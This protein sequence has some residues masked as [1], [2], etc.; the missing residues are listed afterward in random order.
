MDRSRR[1]SFALI[2]GCAFG[3]AACSSGQHG[4]AAPSSSGTRASVAVPATG[5]HY[6]ASISLQGQPEVT[7]D[8]KNIVVTV[9]VKNTGAGTFGSQTAPHNV[10][11][12][13]HS[14][15]AS[16]AVV[17]NDLARG[18]LPQVKPGATVTATI[19]MPTDQLIGNRAEILPVQEGVAWFDKWGTTPLIVGPF[20]TCSGTAGTTVCGPSGKYALINKHDIEDATSY[21]LRS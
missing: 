11:L 5:Q 15:D 1:L 17:N 7:A 9:Q 8:G 18:H 2:L 21:A 4:Q 6:R 20:E 14:I 10:N 3:L 12:G 13:A 16:G 19:R